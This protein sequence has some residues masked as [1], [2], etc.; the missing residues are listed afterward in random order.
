MVEVLTETSTKVQP[1][2]EVSF[3]QM[4]S[5]AKDKDDITVI[6][7]KFGLVLAVD[8][9]MT[10]ENIKKEL[11][12]NYEEMAEKSEKI[13]AESTKKMATEDDP[14]VRMRFMIMD[15]KNPDEAP[16]FEFN[17]DCGKAIPAGGVI[18]KWS[19]VHGEVCTVPFSMYEFLR[20][21]SIPRSKWVADVNAP[22]GK[23][24]VTYQQKRFN[25]ELLISK[26]QVLQLQ[27]TA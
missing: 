3:K 24:C 11:I 21:L 20:N 4:I 18:P 13:T 16:L 6:A 1:G 26:E 15:I 12:T 19:F 2:E 14:P 27:K 9:R 17:H 8:N 25:C 5:A 22:N 10:L 23:R 7:E